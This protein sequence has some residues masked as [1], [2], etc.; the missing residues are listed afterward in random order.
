[1]TTWIG[2]VRVSKADGSQVLDLQI[3]ALIKAGVQENHIYQDEASGRSDDRPG[4]QACLKS[5]R[6]GDTLVVW[7][8]DRLG[9]D[10]RHLVNLVAE[11]TEQ[12]I[13]LKVLTGEGAAIDTTTANGRLI[14]AIFAGLA[15]F[16]R[17][18]IAER[19]KAGLA[20]A[21]ARGRSGGRPFKMTTA[22]LRLAQ[23]AMGKPETKVGDLCAEL[24]ITRQTLYRFVGP[25]GELRADGERLL[26]R[27][28]R[29][30][31]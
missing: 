26:E 21:R 12:K 15:E 4:L 5:L 25:K 19:T 10:L 7:K 24:G 18:L 31:T 1:M 28:K 16:E 6:T 30:K 13:G 9:R 22:K 14:F 23:A 8:L 2:Y 29:S 20:A 11:L 27:R 3:D 17:E